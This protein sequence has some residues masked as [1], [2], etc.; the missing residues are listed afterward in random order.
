M[1]WKKKEIA[2]SKSLNGELLCAKKAWERPWRRRLENWG[3][4]GG[5]AITGPWPCMASLPSLLQLEDKLK[6]ASAPRK[7]YLLICL[8]KTYAFYEQTFQMA[9]M[10]NPSPHGFLTRNQ[11][12]EKRGVL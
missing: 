7:L 3:H 12:M 10:I 2:K 11:K 8:K 4:T 6:S 1:F 5:E 9:N